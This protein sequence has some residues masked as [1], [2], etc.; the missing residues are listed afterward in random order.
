MVTECT[1]RGKKGLDKPRGE[2]HSPVVN[3]SEAAN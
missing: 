3:T 1:T 2:E